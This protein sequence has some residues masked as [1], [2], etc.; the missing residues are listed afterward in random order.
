M[1]S[2]DIKSPMRRNTDLNRIVF[3]NLL[4]FLASL[5]L[6]LVVWGI[7]TTSTNPVQERSYPPITIQVVPDPGLLIV[8]Q[9][10]R[11]ARVTVRTQQSILS[12]LTAADIV[13][14][15]DLAGLGPGT[16]TIELDVD[17]ARRAEADT[18]PRQITVSLEEEQSQQVRI[19]ANV[20]QDQPPGYTRGDIT[21][22]VSQVM[23]RGAASKV[24]QVVEAQ[25][26]LDLNN[27]RDTLEQDVRLI[28][29]DA[30]GDEVS[31]LTLEPQTARVTV[32]ISQRNDV[33]EISVLPNVDRNTLPE[34][35]LVA[36]L[37]YEP[38]TVLVIGSSQEMLDAIPDTLLTQTID[39]TN[40]TTD[41]E[42]SVPVVLPD[43]G[44]ALLGDQ[45]I[46]ISVSI[47]APSFTRQFENLSVEVIGL[48]STLQIQTIPA[49]VTILVTGPQPVVEALELEDID[50]IIDVVELEP[51]TYDVEPRVIVNQG[52][53]QL[54]LI[55]ILPTTITATIT[56]NEELGETTQP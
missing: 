18:Q 20:V 44:L 50:V 28:P 35:Y 53:V 19:T 48:D 32:P 24:Q 40:R 22:D 30:E 9:D 45:V 42:V 39:L 14:R 56:Q 33:R 6:A 15:A 54:D 13:V 1:A 8:D 43:D 10:T 41:F 52:Q 47:V 29:V 2:A 55:S 31:A 11:S 38:Q 25:T 12:L 36:S 49:Q 34:G 51:G 4:W 16:H 37:S 17:V 3:N 5:I 46:T 7:A 23:V 27:Q 21:F 26:I